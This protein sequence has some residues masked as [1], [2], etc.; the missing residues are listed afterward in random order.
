VDALKGKNMRRFSI[1]IL[2]LYFVP[3]AAGA[4]LN[5]D[6]IIQIA[7]NVA[8][9]AVAVDLYD[10]YESFFVDFGVLKFAQE[11]NNPALKNK[12]IENYDKFLKSN[13]LTPGH[14]DK[15]ACGILGFEIYL[16]T[17]DPAYLEIPLSLADDEWLN[18]R[19]DGL[20]KYSRFWTDD[21]F[22]VAV[23]QI[24][25][26]KATGK[27]IY[28]DRAIIQLLAYADK[29]QQQNGLFQHTT[30]IPVFWGRAN[31]WAASAMTITL[32]NMSKEHPKYDTLMNIYKKLMNGILKHQDGDGLW[33]QVL[34]DKDSFQ[35]TSCTAMFTYSFAT[36]VKNGWLD[37]SF[38][39]AAIKGWNGLTGKI[40]NG[41]LK[42]VCCGTDENSSY[43]YYLD[44]PRITGDFHGQAPL[45][46][47]ATALL[48][49]HK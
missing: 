3:L 36:G 39:N 8:S 24:Q 33:H 9:K 2:V 41:L 4:K 44:R 30:K 38:K 18:P 25:A 31:G 6:S 11:T 15:N 1:L 37:D 46:W 47:A 35:E 19:D 17:H 12:V 49:M 13:T 10:K 28:L 22:M 14:V 5:N 21:M 43:N 42:D 32:Q 20:T 34:L 16:Q 27:S 40:E 23:L 48:Q 45:L 29:L 26:Y 7:G